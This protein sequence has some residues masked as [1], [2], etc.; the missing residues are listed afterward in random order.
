M[1]PRRQ[2]GSACQ[3][4]C[5]G[6]R[7]RRYR[8]RGDGV[9]AHGS[10]LFSIA[11]LAAQ[12]T[13][14]EELHEYAARQMVEALK[15]GANHDAMVGAASAIVGTPFTSHPFTPARPPEHTHARIH[16]TAQHTAVALPRKPTWQVPILQPPRIR[17]SRPPGWIGRCGGLLLGTTPCSRGRTAV[18]VQGNSMQCEPRIGGNLGHHC[19]S[20]KEGRGSGRT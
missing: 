7:R 2:C 17:S 13:N 9:E 19:V 5:L 4:P 15:R 10:Q 14:H 8:H 11:C 12:V 6:S 16:I 1:A 3:A 18:L 20:P